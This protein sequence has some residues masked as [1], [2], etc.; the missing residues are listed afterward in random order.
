MDFGTAC[1]HNQTEKGSQ[2]LDASP[3]FG[4]TGT[5]H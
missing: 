5:G 1:G 2:P 3:Q 4:H